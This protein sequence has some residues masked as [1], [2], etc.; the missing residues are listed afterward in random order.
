MM[1]IWSMKKIIKNN[2]SMKT[3]VVMW[4]RN[5]ET[6]EVDSDIFDD[7]GAEACTQAIERN[8]NYQK[9]A[10]PIILTCYEKDI[11]TDKGESNSFLYNTYV[12]LNNAGKFD[13]AEKLRISFK[14]EYN[15]DVRNEPLKS[16]KK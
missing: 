2:S 9:F 4:G 10:V 8:V 7:C 14:K 1:E 5:R 12:I 16:K 15:I 3:F 11:G 6:V 13:L